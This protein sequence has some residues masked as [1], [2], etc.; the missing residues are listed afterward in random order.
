MYKFDLE[1]DE[2]Y[3]IMEGLGRVVL[4]KTGRGGSIYGNDN[5]Y[6]RLAELIR[7]RY[8]STVVVSSNPVDSKCILSDEIDAISQYVSLIDDIV[9]IGVSNGALIG[10]QQAWKNPSIKELLL[11]NG[12]LMINWPRTKVGI[13]LFDGESLFLYGDLDPSYPYLGLLE[14]IDSYRSSYKLLLDVDHTFTDKEERFFDEI[15]QFLSC[16]KQ[17]GK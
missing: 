17:Q 9:F 16:K 5:K 10:A 8:G 2:K 3:G 12:P 15:L 14:L 13:E 11:I 6:L 7:E 4:I 1:I